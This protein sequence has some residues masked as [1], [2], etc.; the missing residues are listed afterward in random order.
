MTQG[1]SGKNISGF[2]SQKF[3]TVLLAMFVLVMGMLDSKPVVAASPFTP[4]KLAGT[5][6]LTS[7]RVVKEKGAT[8]QVYLASKKS[9]EACRDG[10]TRAIIKTDENGY[11]KATGLVYGKYIVHQENYN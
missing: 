8:F 11:G 4:D 3:F 10:E 9:Y 7:A 6:A 5:Y 2:F 1:C